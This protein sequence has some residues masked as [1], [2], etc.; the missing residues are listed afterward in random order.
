MIDNAA[1]S[2]LIRPLMDGLIDKGSSPRFRN[3]S[4]V[5]P[6]NY[7]LGVIQSVILATIF[8]PNRR[9]GVID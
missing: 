8:E 9:S 6:R 2:A 3:E 5:R 7:F 4:P 1:P